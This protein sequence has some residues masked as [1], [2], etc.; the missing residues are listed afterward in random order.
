MA[1]FGVVEYAAIASAV[2][3]AAG[4]GTAGTAAIQQGQTAKKAS[5]INAENQRLTAKSAED[6]AAQQSADQKMKAKRII[7]SQITQAGAGGVDPST[8]TP[9]TM[10]GQTAEFGELDSLRIINNA[11][12]S[13]WGLQ[14]Q[15]DIGEYEGSQAK[16]A[17]YLNAGSTL[18]GGVS[19]A[20]FGYQKAMK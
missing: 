7:A 4:A 19:N 13:A 5:D 20:Y 6:V 14:S 16:S 15:A 17:S 9:L 3:A 8:G 2:I 11:Q 1:D 18:L 12:R 10:E